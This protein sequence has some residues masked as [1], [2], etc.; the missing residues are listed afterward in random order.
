[1]EELGNEYKTLVGKSEDKRPIGRP[2]CR[3]EDNITLDL[4][5]IGKS[6]GLDA[7]GLEY[8]PVVGY[9][10]HGNEPSGSITNG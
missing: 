1:V 7:S 10:E 8:G 4:R 9:F 2:R 3:W 6:C 5:E